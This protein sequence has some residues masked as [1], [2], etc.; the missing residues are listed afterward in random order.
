MVRRRGYDAQYRTFGRLADARAFAHKSETAI[1]DGEAGQ[2]REA[3]RKT[4]ADAID[5]YLAEVIAGRRDKS[6]KRH[7]KYWRDRLG[8]VRIGSVTPDMLAAA[9]GDLLA[10][11]S[12]L[13]STLS[14]ATVRL[15]LASLSALFK[16][17]R[18]EWRWTRSNPVSDVVK[19]K[20]SQERVR[21]LS[22]P[23]RIKLLD[24]CSKSSDPRLHPFV[25]LALSSGARAGELYGLRWSDVYL[26]R[27]TAEAPRGIAVL[28]RTKNK[29]NRPIPLR[30][31]SYRAVSSMLEFKNSDA[32]LVFPAFSGSRFNYMKPFKRAVAAAG[33][34]NFRFH[35]LR[36]TCASYLAMNGATTAEIAEVL[37][38]K[39]LAMVKRYS[40]MSEGH[41]GGVVERMNEK[42]IGG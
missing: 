2:I 35:D 7:F 33:I 11:Q 32:D 20:S 19:P 13:G 3:R 1:N 40:H 34:K 17:A 41:V 5:R 16:R 39:T 24:E 4:L 28:R 8:H 27:G 21:F 22:D 18:M 26:D 37:G 30:G 36:H 31:G 9:K 6:A 15:Y 23:E 25:M 38:H 14:Q 12:R 42:F 10:T 29:E